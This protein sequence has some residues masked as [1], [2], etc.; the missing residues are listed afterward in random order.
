MVYWAH[1]STPP[2]G[3][4]I[5]PVVL[6]LTVVTNRPTDRPR[7]VWWRVAIVRVLCFVLR[8][9]LI[10]SMLK[11]TCCWLDS[12]DGLSDELSGTC[13]VL[14][15]SECLYVVFGQRANR[16]VTDRLY[17]P[18]GQFGH[19]A[20]PTNC[21]RYA[22]CADGRLVDL[23]RCP[24]DRHWRVTSPA[25]YGF[26]DLPQ[27]AGCQPIDVTDLSDP[28]EPPVNICFVSCRIDPVGVNCS[29]FITEAFS[30][31]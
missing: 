20:D 3:T 26:C 9:G 19:F 23:H 12:L 18:H 31:S 5:S 25:G 28:V 7:Y 8:C 21:S 27:T 29:L 4:S 6:G 17:C 22:Q 11:A 16:S 10:N 13:S 30:E 1:E 14:L 2:N 15:I 24:S